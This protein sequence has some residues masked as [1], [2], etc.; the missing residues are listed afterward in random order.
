MGANIMIK[1][2]LSI[3]LVISTVFLTGCF[4]VSGGGWIHS[5]AGG[6]NKATFGFEMLCDQD[7]KEASGTITY[8][9]SGVTVDGY[10][11]NYKGKPKKLALNG[12]I[13]GNEGCGLDAPYAE[14]RGDYTPIPAS[15]GPGGSFRVYVSDGGETG[16]D[17]DD[18]IMIFID[19]GIFAG[20]E[21]DQY[22]QG[23]NISAL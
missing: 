5:A 12:V 2:K 20:Y 11:G 10:G 18:K 7:T 15:V 14:Y 21:N 9:D 6:K 8:H 17:K 4:D 13:A 16:P 1:A 23:G 3:P 19:T 22:L